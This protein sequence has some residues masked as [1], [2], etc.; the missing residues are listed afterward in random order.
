M[1]RHP[2]FKFLS[3]VKLA[4]PLM[5]TVLL[6]VSYGTVVESRY[7]TE[8][9]RLV[10][11]HTVWFQILLCL[12]WVN[13]L[14]AALSRYPW[15][16]HHTGFVV[17]HIGLLTLLVGALVTNNW[18]IDGQL[19]VVE[20]NQGKEVVLGDLVLEVMDRKTNAVDTFAVMRRMSEAGMREL[21]SINNQTGGKLTLLSFLPFA[22]TEKTFAKASDTAS[23]SSSVGVTF[24]LKSA[25]FDVTQSL[26]SVENP[27]FQLGPA[28]LSLVVHKLGETPDSISKTVKQ[29][30][31]GHS[32]KT[33]VVQVFKKGSLEPLK[34]IP[35]A[36]LKSAPV[37]VGPLILVATHTFEQAMVGSKGKVEEGGKKGANPAVELSIAHQGK[38][39]REVAFA[40]FPTFSLHNE[41]VFGYTF[42]YIAS[43]EPAAPTDSVQSGNVIQFHVYPETPEKTLVKLLKGGT[44]VLSKWA[45]AEETIETP[46]MGMQLTVNGVVFGGV[47]TEEVK[48]TTPA[49]RSEMP[50]SAV[51]VKPAGGAPNESFWLIEGSSRDFVANGTAY[52]VYYGKRT[53]KLPFQVYLEKFTK[54]DYPGTETPMSF[55]SEVK[56]DDETM[57][58]KISMN[59]PLTLAGFTLYQASYVLQPGQPPASIFSVN[60]DPGRWLKYIGSLILVTGIV[61]FTLMRSR[62]FSPKRG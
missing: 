37:E 54:T 7:N 15:K 21:S 18:G 56:I 20:K 1:W 19:H 2:F 43:A 51:L 9:A 23:E 14:F 16:R 28:H 22:K 26:N 36:Q 61:T 38:T 59:E 60:W 52:Q 34:I 44:S 27:E 50:P 49:L 53:L 47:E 12:L 40:R 29:V 11:Y 24:R 41:G 6:T 10:V 17:T 35:L 13:I 46:W 42:R 32:S 31:K 3:S 39:E 48:P 58:R 4:V 8:M 25:F 55:E 57:T 45:K 33:S 5:L 62:M 30:S